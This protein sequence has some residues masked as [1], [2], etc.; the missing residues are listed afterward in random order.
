MEE[1]L[2]AARQYIDAKDTD[3]AIIEYKNAI[4][5]APQAPALRFELGRAYLL[6]HNYDAA[7]KEL[8][9]ALE[10]GHPAAE[11]IPLLSQA[12]Q[13]TGA[14]NA[15]AQLDYGEEGMSDD[16]TAEVGFYKLQALTQLG[17]EKEAQ[18]LIDELE[19]LNTDSVYKDLILSYRS[20]LA[21]DIASALAQTQALYEQAPTN[22]DVMLQLARLYLAD[23]QKQEAV[24]IYQNYVKNYPNDLTSKFALISLLVE[25]GS[26]AEAEPFVD[27]LLK[28]NAEH[29]LLNQYKGIIASSKGDYENGLKYL[30][31]AIRNGQNAPVVRMVAGF[32]AYQMQDYKAAS[33]HLSMVASSL[34]DNHPG[35]R[36]LADSLLRLGQSEDAT[37][38]LNR[39]DGELQADA[40]LFSKAGF[41]LLKEGNVADARKMVDKS[42]ELS[43]TAA[44][45]ARLGVLQLSLNDIDGLVNLEA[46]A[47]KAP[48]SVAT[49]QTLLAAYVSTNQVEKA[50]E[51]ATQWQE[52]RPRDPMP[53]VYLA[54]LALKS[55]DKATAE[56]EMSRA[57][58]LAPDS[59]EVKIAKA[60]LA[61]IDK[62]LEA[63]AAI[64]TAI[65]KAEPVNIQ[66]LTMQYGIA[67]EKGETSAVAKQIEK[68]LA[69]SPGNEDLRLL[70]SRIY[71]TNEDF[72]KVLETL[73]PI[74]E[75]AQT[76]MPYW[77]IKGQALIRDNQ[78][79]AANVHFD[80][81]LAQYPQ[82]KTATL[83]KMLLN[84]AQG[85]YDDGLALANRFLQ[86]RS[87]SQVQILKAYFLA[88]TREV[89]KSR[90]II[91]P[92]PEKVK[93][94]PFVR[95]ISARLSLLEGKGK[96]AI[97]DAM[98]AYQK[99]PNPQ[100]TIL[101][102]ASY[103]SAGKNDQ[104]YAFLQEHVR[105]YPNDTQ[106]MMLL[107]ER[108][109]RQDK[110]GAAK[111]YE[112]ILKV[113]PDNFV[114]LNNLAYL[115]L[116]EGEL[117]KAR[118]LAKRAV[119]QKPKNAD[120]VDTLAQVMIKQGEKEK[121]L[122]LYTK[123]GAEELRTDEVYLNYVELL[124]ET[125]KRELAKRRLA[126]R[127]F[128]REVSKER[129][130]MLQNKL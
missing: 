79:Q 109:I 6:K 106:T 118:Q 100:N 126:S 25:T 128:E 45:L 43:N 125:G 29:P 68:L 73:K 123:L 39:V 24:G 67:K 72:P 54:E 98:A 56:A 116:E 99:T 59:S 88:M 83:G 96:A 97:P 94:L 91:E 102:V 82:D 84:D 60:K 35:L 7:E 32:S 1:H 22:K 75:D 124:I 113:M 76:P 107:A 81:W 111:L 114:V 3:A 34:P 121:A 40:A 51:L 23:K 86:M 127:K 117:D 112:K 129:A 57:E 85:N 50:R 110:G 8:N 2:S 95:G 27:E 61:V 4:K 28:R 12:Y 38:V 33:Q 115:Y 30:E 120:A 21:K 104:S 9:R 65:L 69:R 47:A 31:K 78:A 58:S 37:E 15:L 71:F 64:L 20:L 103:E 93:A 89:E 52:T 77:S 108:M 19:N 101:V 53:H 74:K 46:A 87:D 14:D 90:A 16:Q 62:D 17:E 11:V 66:A 92:L 63:A 122:D 119:D 48:E 36:M 70:L 42:S 80:K 18:A 5:A 44:D 49:Q 41:Q 26:T 10:L 105:K 130:K 55:G 13:Q